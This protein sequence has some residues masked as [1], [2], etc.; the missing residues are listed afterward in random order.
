M[1]EDGNGTAEDDLR[2]EKVDDHVEDSSTSIDMSSK[3]P[4][5]DHFNN[6][7]SDPVKTNAM[8]KF[9]LR[10]ILCVSMKYDYFKCVAKRRNLKGHY[11]E[12]SFI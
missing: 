7:E 6:E 1:Q 2:A 5:I 8:S 3:K 11:E 9:L 12:Q 10:V 4:G